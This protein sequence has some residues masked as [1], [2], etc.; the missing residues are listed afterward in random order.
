MAVG[1]VDVGF[2]LGGK[3]R[4]EIAQQAV[5]QLHHLLGIDVER[6]TVHRPQHLV[7][8][9]GGTGDRQEFPARANG[10][11]RESSESFSLDR[12]AGE[13]REIQAGTG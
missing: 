13:W 7:G 1:D 12:D 6:G 9:G 2:A 5:G 3:Q 10:H 8:H 4:R 11:C